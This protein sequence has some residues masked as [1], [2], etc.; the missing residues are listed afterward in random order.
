MKAAANPKEPKDI[1]IYLINS[2]SMDSI[3]YESEYLEEDGLM[4]QK[5]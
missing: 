2:I 4:A 1:S 3:Y 5:S